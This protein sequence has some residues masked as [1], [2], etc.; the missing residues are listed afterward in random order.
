MGSISYKSTAAPSIFPFYDNLYIA[1][2][3]SSTEL[4]T[5]YTKD[6]SNF[7]KIDIKEQSDQQPAIII[8]DGKIVIAFKAASSDK[9]L[10]VYSSDGETWTKHELVD[11]LSK[12]APALTVFDGKLFLAYAGTNAGDLY[13]MST[14]DL[15]S[16]ER[17]KV[18]N[19]DKTQQT[20]KTPALAVYFGNLYLAFTSKTKKELLYVTSTD[21]VTWS[22]SSKIESS[23]SDFWP[24]LTTFD[25]KLYI[26]YKSETSNQI[27]YRGYTREEGWGEKLHVT[28]DVR[29]GISSCVFN[30][31][32]YIGY[33][34]KSDHLGLTAPLTNTNTENQ[35]LPKFAP[36]NVDFLDVW[37]EGRI[38]DNGFIT[39]FTS[40]YNFN[41]NVKNISNGPNEKAP[42]PN[43]I[44]VESYDEGFI[45]L[46]GNSVNRITLMGAPIESWVAL[47]MIRVLREDTGIIYLYNPDSNQLD[48][49]N[50]AK[51]D[52][53][54]CYIADSPASL[55]PPFNEVNFPGPV[56]VYSWE[57]S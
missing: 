45:P 47:E 38:N 8:Y 53:L 29:T 35:N 32:L 21:G 31:K 10:I 49:F 46:N 52:N 51:P 13:V 20:E 3:G 16:W 18:A 41:K 6:T 7:S 9:L 48:N 36:D 28:S 30:Q 37:G 23:N 24:S 50:D 33:L 5:Y 39:G 22:G 42:I 15:E 56:Y 54:I 34:G 55:S 11:H 19:K 26:C 1:A 40:A 14:T 4:Y 2:K 27:Y 17:N 25:G 43:L 12:N 57:N 44:P